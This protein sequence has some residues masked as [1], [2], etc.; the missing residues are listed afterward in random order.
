MK[1]RVDAGRK[2]GDGTLDALSTMEGAFKLSGVTR[3]HMQ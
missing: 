2:V 3:K 1:D